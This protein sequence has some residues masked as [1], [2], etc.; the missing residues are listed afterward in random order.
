ML[1]EK[2]LQALSGWGPLLIALAFLVGALVVFTST[3]VLAEGR[4]SH[5]QGV[6]VSAL[7]A[8]LFGVLGIVMLFGFQAVAPNDARV[9]LLFGRYQGSISESG[10]YWVNPFY[11]K[12]R[13]SLRLRNFETG[14][15]ATPEVKDATGK[16]IHAKGRGPG[17]PSKV[18]DRD[19]NPVDITA[20]VVWRVVNTVEA[21]FEVDDYEDFVG[22][23]SEAA[24]RSLAAQYPYDNED[25]ERSLCVAT[26]RI[27]ASSFDLRFNSGLRRLG[28]KWSR[29]AFATSRTPPRSPRPCCNASRHRRSSQHAPGSWMERL[30][31]SKWPWNIFPATR[32]WT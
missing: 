13:I 15:V 8:I 1:Q 25:H 22:V 2:R 4:S 3:V 28:S 11:S 32:S 29:Y 5:G 27:S 16:L 17:R 14:S 26:R 6:W 18:N 23:Q 30:G 7:V 10:F 24:L 31:W 20:V 9:L 21:L 12:K 19:G